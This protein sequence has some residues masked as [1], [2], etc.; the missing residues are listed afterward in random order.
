[1]YKQTFG[2]EQNR[3]GIELRPDESSRFL[4]EITSR[5]QSVLLADINGHTYAAGELK[6]YGKSEQWCRSKLIPSF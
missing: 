3:D 1:M 5:A 4:N 2:R 6:L